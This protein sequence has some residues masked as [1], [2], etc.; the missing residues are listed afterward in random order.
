MRS[1]LKSKIH[2]APVT[3]VNLDHEGGITTV[4]FQI[5]SLSKGED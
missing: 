4:R 5:S 2:R 3:E 1:M